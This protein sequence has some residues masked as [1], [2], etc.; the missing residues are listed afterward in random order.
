MLRCMESEQQHVRPNHEQRAS[1]S[2]VLR[3]LDNTAG[4]RKYFR[5]LFNATGC[6]FPSKSIRKPRV[7]TYDLFLVHHIV[8]VDRDYVL[9][10]LGSWLDRRCTDNDVT[11]ERL[12]NNETRFSIK[13]SAT[14]WMFLAD[15]FFRV[16]KWKTCCHTSR[17]LSLLFPN[18]LLSNWPVFSIRIL[19]FFLLASMFEFATA[20]YDTAAVS[21]HEDPI[22]PFG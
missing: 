13:C 19:E 2:L 8:N 3:G 12:Q 10:I 9:S 11:S 22:V 1:L 16:S 4:I 6:R 20:P 18:E 7:H 5:L 17:T 15:Y 21:F 14:G